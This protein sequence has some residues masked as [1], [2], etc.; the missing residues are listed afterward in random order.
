MGSG[1]RRIQ[2]SV[3]ALGYSDDASAQ[4][5]ACRDPP[6]QQCQEQTSYGLVTEDG[7]WKI[8]SSTVHSSQT[9]QAS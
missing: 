9:K 5:A 2:T 1:N 4:P 7:L 8:D 3:W 6:L